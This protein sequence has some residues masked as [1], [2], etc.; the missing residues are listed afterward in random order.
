MT[1]INIEFSN[2]LHR[3][4][5]YLFGELN[6]LKLKKRQAGI[7]IID[8]GMGN[9]DKP[10]PSHI[11]DK[12]R[13]VILDSRNHRYSVSKGIYNLRKAIA[14]YYEKKWNVG[15]DPDS[16]AIAVIGTKE[17]LSHLSLAL[18]GPGDTALVPNPA[19][20]IHLYSVILAGANV[21]NI[22]LSTPE[23]FMTNLK[24]TT[25]SLHPKP[26]VLFLNYPNNPTTQVV[27][28]PFFEEVVQFAK[29]HNMVVIHDFAY[30]DITFD[31]YKAPSFL[32]AKGA[33]DVGVE[34]FT[35]SKS[36]NMP[37][38]RIGFCVGNSE[39]VAALAKIKGYYDYGIFQSIQIAAIVALKGD[40]TCVEENAKLYQHRRD[41]LCDGLNELGWPIEKPKASMFVWSPIPEA[42]RKMGSLKFS[43]FLMEEAEISVSPGIGFGTNGDDFVRMALVENDNRIRQALKNIKRALP[44]LQG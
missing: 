21:I 40:Q 43:R 26:K 42:Y 37:G 28:L 17:G 15:L 25:E 32:Q 29:F 12:I 35:M 19:F 24:K 18:L 14:Y 33:K 11:V 9:P 23:I 16:E 30:G 20:P 34:F 6:D 2:R 44:E 22:P 39:L 4:P 3:L 41:L 1:K 5:P 13:E 31:G 8:F 38:W 27:D 36:Y 7:D 10:T